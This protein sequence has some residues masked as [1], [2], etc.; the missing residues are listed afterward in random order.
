MIESRTSLAVTS[1]PISRAACSHSWLWIRSSSLVHT[2]IVVRDPIG[3]LVLIPRDPILPH[4]DDDILL[5]LLKPP[6]AHRDYKDHRNED[7]NGPIEPRALDRAFSQNLQ[8][9][10]RSSLD[11]I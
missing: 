2:I 3:P 8:H 11:K 1:T 5:V 6:P 4:A 10:V 7:H 9:A